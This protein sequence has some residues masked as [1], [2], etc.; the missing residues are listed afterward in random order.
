MECGLAVALVLSAVCVLGLA[1]FCHQW[2]TAPDSPLMH[3]G[4]SRQAAEFRYGAGRTVTE[5]LWVNAP[6]SRGQRH[7]LVL[8]I[9][10]SPGLAVLYADLLL[11][12]T[13]G[14]GPCTG[15]AVSYPTEASCP[16]RLAAM[17]E[18]FATVMCSVLEDDQWSG[19]SVCAQSMG[20]WLAVCGLTLVKQKNLRCW[21]GEIS[22]VYSL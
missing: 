19:V 20:A 12:V 4:V 10:G 5:V 13:A 8:I 1:I 14:I 17:S 2:P 9:P 15:L 6:P 7:H 22:R 11:K 16:A 18:Q 3:P 21:T